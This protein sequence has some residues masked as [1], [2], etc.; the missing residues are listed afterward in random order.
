MKLTGLDRE[1]DLLRLAGSLVVEEESAVYPL[2]R[3]LLLIYRARTDE[4]ERP[5]LKLIGILGG[6]SLSIGN[7]DGLAYNGVRLG[8]V[9]AERI[10]QPNLYQPNRKVRNVNADPSSV[11]R[12]SGGNRC[13]TPA[14]GIEHRIPLIRARRDDSLQ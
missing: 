8:H 11:E 10:L 14:E 12:L 3:P 7:R 9:G 2:V 13:A 6:K 4:A 5:P 1:D